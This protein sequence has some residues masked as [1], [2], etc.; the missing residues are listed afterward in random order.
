LHP[1]NRERDEYNFLVSN[2]LTQDERYKDLPFVIGEPGFRFYAGTPLTTESNVNIG[3]FFALDTKPHPEFSYIEKE[4][5][6]HMGML[7]MDFLKVR[8]QASDG[9]HAARLSRGI[10]LFVEGYSSFE[11]SSSRPVSGNF[12]AQSGHPGISTSSPRSPSTSTQNSR[13]DL[14]SR[15]RSRSVRSSSSTADSVDARAILSSLDSQMAARLANKSGG[16]RGL[17]AKLWTFRRAANLI[18]ES[19]ELE[20]KSG[21][22]FLEAGGDFAQEIGTE[23]DTSNSCALESSKPASIV[24]LSTPEMAF[25]PDPDHSSREPFPIMKL[26]E[27]FL[28][29]ML[30]RHKRGRIWN[31]HR[32][33]QLTSSDSEDHFGQSDSRGRRRNSTDQAKSRKRT[34]AK[35]NSLLNQY[36]PGATQVL[37]VPLWNAANSQLFGGFFCWTNVEHKVFSPSIELS[38]LLSFGSSIM[39]ECSRIETVI[40]DQQKDDFLGSIS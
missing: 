11:R 24:A 27:E 1:S 35:D 26:D 2:D 4:T 37:F 22:V 14:S 6:G 15:S 29:R 31:F 21:V 36:F 5:M 16:T 8:R 19:L 38:S 3:C 25:G 40:S 30:R 9:R 23:S 18:R 12:G 7:I 34:K 32:D 33:G 13:D 17:P 20:E 28:R 10:N 39:A